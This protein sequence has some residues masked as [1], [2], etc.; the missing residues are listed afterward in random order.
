MAALLPLSVLNVPIV[1]G[2]A[3]QGSE[4][5]LTEQTLIVQSKGWKKG[6]FCAQTA[7]MNIYLIF[8]QT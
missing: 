5:T 3:R 1:L 8:R 2:A 4:C 7:T 6:W